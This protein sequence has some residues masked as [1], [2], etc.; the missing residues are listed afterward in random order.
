MA[1]LRAVPRTSA[2]EVAASILREQIRGRTILRAVENLS[3]VF[4]G[5]GE[6]VARFRAFLQGASNVSLLASSCELFAESSRHDHP[7]YG[8]STSTIS[9]RWS[10]TKPETSWQPW[11]T[12]AVSRSWSRPFAR[13]G[14]ERAWQ[15]PTT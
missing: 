2:V 6:E 1:R 14:P 7:F 8:F 15:P 4:L 3:Q 10:G 13:K 5:L 9:T 12:S 11:L